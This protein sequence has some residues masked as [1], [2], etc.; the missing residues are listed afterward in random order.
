MKLSLLM[1]MLLISLLFLNGCAV[2]GTQEQ[3]SFEDQ[4]S[5][6][7]AETLMVMQSVET[8]VA[9]TVSAGE[10]EQPTLEATAEPPH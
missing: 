4:A 5:T 8:I 6:S 9:M 1:S 10:I 2:S 3:L 7:V